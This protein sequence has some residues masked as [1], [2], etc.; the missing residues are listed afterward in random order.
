MPPVAAGF[1]EADFFAADFFTVVFLADAGEADFIA[2]LAATF[3]GDADLAA[4]FFIAAF[5]ADA[6]AA[7]FFG[8]LFF[9]AVLGMADFGIADFADAF[10]AVALGAADF[11]IAD[12][13]GGLAAAAF[14]GAA[15]FVVDFFIVVFA[16]GGSAGRGRRRL[17]RR[18]L[19]RS[20]GRVR[21]GRGAA[22]SRVGGPG[23]CSPRRPPHSGLANCRAGGVQCRDT[24][25][26]VRRANRPRAADSAATTHASSADGA[27]RCTRADLTRAVAPAR[28]PPR[29]A[30][31]GDEAAR[32]DRP[33]SISIHVSHALGQESYRVEPRGIDAPILVGRG[34]GADLVVPSSAV[35]A[36]HAALFVHGGRWAVHD[37]GSRNGTFLNGGRIERPQYLKPGDRVELGTEVEPPTIDVFKIDADAAE[38]WVPLAA[39]APD[40]A[41]AAKPSAT[42]GDARRRDSI[43]TARVRPVSATP[44]DDD[45]RVVTTDAGAT[46]TGAVL[47]TADARGGE[48]DE[49]AEHARSAAFPSESDAGT[50]G[51]IDWMAVDPA[52]VPP[53]PPGARRRRRGPAWPAVVAPLAATA[54]VVG[55]GWYFYQRS[56]DRPM[57]P[58]AAPQSVSGA[59]RVRGGQAPPIDPAAVAASED[60][61]PGPFGDSPAPVEGTAVDEP[62]DAPVADRPTAGATPTPP[63]GEPDADWARVLE[64]SRTGP[65]RVALYRLLEFETSHPDRRPAEA[66]A[67]RAAALDRLWWSRVGALVD[68]RNAARAEARSAGAEVVR[69]PL[70]EVAARV[71]LVARRDAAKATA[72]DLAA[73]LRRGMDYDA[74][75]PPPGDGPA[76]DALRRSRDPARFADWS[77]QVVDALR[78]SNGGRL[79]WE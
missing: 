73:E 66:E 3:F 14:L 52:A 77:D 69:T 20:V 26:R 48:A 57:I 36:R 22:L 71:D 33:M 16:M 23:V 4:D 17:A 13:L 47:G 2:G 41:P 61:G 21:R 68:R 25:M 24:A 50:G 43:P 79:P 15:V 9:A 75:A 51:A 35:S 60:K 65:P 74:A 8:A 49:S 38:R 18:G 70:S 53:T 7:A 54:L 58:V 10:F 28:R 27:S 1:F 59:P 39:V 34:S 40:A 32:Y 30:R 62:A 37:L 11:F 45:A 64:A 29:R 42:G 72:D 12:A 46:T 31:A 6:F 5:G 56:R 63:D 44:A 78:P 67:L 19:G 55:A 76:L